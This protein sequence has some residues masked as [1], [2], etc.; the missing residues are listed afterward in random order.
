M[1]VTAQM[2]HYHKHLLTCG[3]DSSRIFLSP[4][5]PTAV[6]SAVSRFS[7]GLRLTG[8]RYRSGEASSIETLRNL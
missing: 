7:R 3:V 8:P 5:F 6:T 2:C 1:V 4:I